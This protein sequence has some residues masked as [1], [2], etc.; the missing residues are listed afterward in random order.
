LHVVSFIETVLVVLEQEIRAEY[1][2][3]VLYREV[4]RVA[5]L[6]ARGSR[7]TAVDVSEV[8]E[9]DRT[10]R[11][12]CTGKRC[13]ISRSSSL[14]NDQRSLR[15]RFLRPCWLAPAPSWVEHRLLDR[16]MRRRALPVNEL[17]DKCQAT[18]VRVR[19]LPERWSRSEHC[20]TKTH[21]VGNACFWTGFS[22]VH[23]TSGRIRTF[24][25]LIRFF[26]FRTQVLFQLSCWERPHR[27]NRN[28]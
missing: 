7:L 25:L 15:P 19:H 6:V 21:E 20:G 13:P 12:S 9:L 27:L 17:M 22:L 10:R 14:H 1:G 5:R 11:Q 28:D 23:V 24:T 18:R 26:V 3:V 2:S 4:E 8:W 16:M